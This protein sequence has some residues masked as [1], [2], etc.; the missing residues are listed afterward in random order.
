MR[1]YF[2]INKKLHLISNDYH[3]SKQV[4]PA[5]KEINILAKFVNVYFSQYKDQAT[6]LRRNAKTM[7]IQ[8]CLNV[9]NVVWTL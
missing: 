5:I 4:S 3:A 9:R 7:L 2:L 1:K 6:Q 8:R